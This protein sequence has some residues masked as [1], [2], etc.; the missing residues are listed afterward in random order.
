[1]LAEF[2]RKAIATNQLEFGEGRMVLLGIRGI[3]LPASTLVELLLAVRERMGEN[4]WDMLY[5]VG[6][7]HA[8]QNIIR[9]V[10]KKMS[11]SKASLLQQFG[12]SA[13]VMGLGRWEF[14]EYLPEAGR[15]K[16]RLYDSAIAEALK[17]KGFKTRQP[18]DSFVA[19]VVAGIGEAAFD[20]PVEAKETMCAALG[21]PYCE[22]IARP[23][24]K[25]KSK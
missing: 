14:T 9:A 12:S 19:G 24:S 20:G 4:V 23:A 7:K 5:E 6:K 13:N 2:I 21:A 25:K 8:E 17:K 10:A 3:V 11:I 1:M 22:F 16:V 18:V 15:L